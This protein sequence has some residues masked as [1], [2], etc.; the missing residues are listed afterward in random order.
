MS[1]SMYL[2]QIFVILSIV[3]TVISQ[4]YNVCGTSGLRYVYINEELEWVGLG[5][6]WTSET[7]RRHNV[8]IEIVFATVKPSDPNNLGSIKILAFVPTPNDFDVPRW[9]MAY[10]WIFPTQNPLPDV[11]DIIWNGDSICNSTA[12]RTPEKP[13]VVRVQAVYNDYTKERSFSAEII[14]SPETTTTPAP[15]SLYV[16]DDDSETVGCGR[17]DT[18]NI[19]VPLVLEGQT[20][21]RG[22]WPW[23]VSVYSYSNLKL[24]F[25]CGATLISNKLVV[26]AAHC[27]FDV[28]NRQVK[29][30][31]VL[32]ILG[33]YNLKRPKDE[34]TKIVYPESVNIHPKYQ[35][36]N[37]IHSDIA[38]VVIPERVRFTTYIRPACLWKGPETKTSLVGKTG[39]I[40]GWGRDENGNFFTEL[41]K[42]SEIPVISD[43]TCLRSNEAFVRITSEVTFCAGWRNGTEGPCNGDS[44]GPLVFE[45]DGRWTLRGVVST[46]LL[47][48]G[49]NTCN[50]NEYVVFTDV[51]QFTD[52]ITS[53]DTDYSY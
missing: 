8:T 12:V 30:D 51:T 6:A 19:Y 28:N 53:F 37:K 31:D 3:C 50:L 32:I 29:S 2:L 36:L 34:R 21:E 22:Q 1:H 5:W 48:D 38:V 9:N 40:A 10:E 13:Y 16:N 47:T 41:P 25:Q 20:I 24:G 11:L 35:K 23:L 33:Q 18:S 44:G 14:E 4:R 17:V 49:S 26:T 45:R 42:Q 27:F 7:L 43:E 15:I 39:F 46:S 52:W